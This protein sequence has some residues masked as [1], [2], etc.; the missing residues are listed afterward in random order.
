MRRSQTAVPFDAHGHGWAVRES[1]DADSPPPHVADR[2]WS[3]FAPPSPVRAVSPILPPVRVV[4]PILP[5]VRRPPLVAVTTAN[6]RALIEEIKMLE[7]TVK[8][9][10]L[11]F[12]QQ[13]RL[14]LAVLKE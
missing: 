1:A 14:L 9:L 2:C 5:P 3:A 10:S 12:H 7:R 11:V 4:S 6:E 13:N 8:R